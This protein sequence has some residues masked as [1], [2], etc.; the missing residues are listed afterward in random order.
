MINVTESPVI[1]GN[2]IRKS[3]GI[4]LQTPVA[5]RMNSLVYE[6]ENV[7]AYGHN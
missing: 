7:V 1:F 6:K 2:V 3:C 4:W 5:S